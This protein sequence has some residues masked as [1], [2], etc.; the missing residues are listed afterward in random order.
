MAKLTARQKAFVNEYLIDL[1]ATQAAIRAGYSQKTAAEQ[2]T[3]LLTNVNIQDNLQKRM[4]DREKRTEI[5][6]DMI[7][8]ELASVA[9][10]N[11]TDYATI[12]PDEMGAAEVQFKP[13]DTLTKEKKA[14]IS[15]IKTSQTGIEVKLCDKMKALE[16][17]GKHL[18]MFNDKIADKNNDVTVII[19]GNAGDWSK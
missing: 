13:T 14:A 6:Q 12:T 18:G 19:N 3:R 16:L 15:G 5:T 11:G 2:A 4:S 10:A 7:L 8:N 9:F 17:L 1:N